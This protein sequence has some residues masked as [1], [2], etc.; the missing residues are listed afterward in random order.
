MLLQM[1]RP[2]VPIAV[3]CRVPQ[4]L[5]CEGQISL[6]PELSNGDVLRV[7]LA[8]S[9]VDRLHKLIGKHPHLTACAGV[10]FV[11]LGAE[12]VRDLFARCIVAHEKGAGSWIDVTSL[13]A[14]DRILAHMQQICS[15]TEVLYRMLLIVKHGSAWGPVILPVFKTGGRQVF[16]SPVRS[17]RT[18]FRHLPSTPYITRTAF[19]SPCL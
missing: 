3:H 18:R 7:A 6:L 13:I 17:T 10:E 4:V 12:A 2:H 19:V 15:S 1:L 5:H 14:H 11:I 8:F 16:L 9:G